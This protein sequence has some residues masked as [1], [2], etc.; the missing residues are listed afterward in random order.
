MDR[1]R[2]LNCKGNPEVQLT[3]DVMRPYTT[4]SR[5]LCRIRCRVEQI[6]LT[7]TLTI[8]IKF[9]FVEDERKEMTTNCLC[10][11]CAR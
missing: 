6:K 5:H 10:I 3:F 4:P 7:P 9:H 11:Y 2:R 8:S 1:A